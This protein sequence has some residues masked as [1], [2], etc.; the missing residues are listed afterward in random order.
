MN[1]ITA[2]SPTW[3]NP[4]HTAITLTVNFKDLGELPFSAIPDDTEAHGRDIYARAVAGEF[5]AV[6][7]Y[8]APVPDAAQLLATF[9]QQARAALAAS[10]TTVLRCLAVGVPVPDAWTAYRA[11]LR[12]CLS[13]GTPCVLPMRP[14]YPAGT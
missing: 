8:A 14:A 10:D 2:H 7:E 13:A 3:Q 6:A 9:H 12:I 5:G 4:E 11:D 1:I